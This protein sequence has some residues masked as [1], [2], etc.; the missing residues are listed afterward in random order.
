MSKP[1]SLLVIMA[2][3]GWSG[4]AAA[5]ADWSLPS[6]KSL[7]I[8]L[9]S[10]KN[11]VEQMRQRNNWLKSEIQ[12]L[13]LKIADSKGPA[14]TPRRA[15]GSD[16]FLR[17]PPQQL[18][19]SPAGAPSAA[20]FGPRVALHE[21]RLLNEI[22]V[23]EQEIQQMEAQLQGGR[24][25][26]AEVLSEQEFHEYESKSK[27]IQANIKQL[28]KQL[29]DFSRQNAGALKAYD[30][31][32][33]RN[34]ELKKS[35]QLLTGSLQ[36]SGAE[37]DRL[38]KELTET[39]ARYAQLLKESQSG[40]ESLRS[41]NRSLES[42]LKKADQRISGKRENLEISDQE[43]ETLM[44][45]R[46]FIQAENTSLKEKFFHMQENWKEIQESAKK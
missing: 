1:I 46:H 37:Y 25:A 30:E 13:E 26:P 3:L 44:E 24:E 8:S 32:Q 38:S 11:S 28:Q 23:V 12:S 41:E 27:M 20:M 17:V 29:D 45:N 2:L 21:E 31:L 18:P 33:S 10:L 15:S 40:L 4:T 9:N 14:Q 19:G 34:L 36:Q 16:P 42:V 6:D 22:T 39:E 7:S 43:I 35:R 5:Q